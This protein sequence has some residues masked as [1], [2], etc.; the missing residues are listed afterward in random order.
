MP[1]NLLIEALF[2][3]DGG[4]F[5]LSRIDPSKSDMVVEGVEECRIESGELRKD[6]S[7]C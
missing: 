1:I 4:A 7:G 3:V 5:I 6:S 2:S